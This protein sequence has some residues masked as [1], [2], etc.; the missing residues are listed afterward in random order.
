MAK[1][2]SRGIP[3]TIPPGESSVFSSESSVFSVCFGTESSES[4]GASESSACTFSR[5]FSRQGL[6]SRQCVQSSRSLR[7]FSVCRVPRSFKTQIKS[8]VF[9]VFRL[10]SLAFSDFV[11]LSVPEIW[12][13]VPRGFPGESPGD[14]PGDSPGNPPGPLGRQGCCCTPSTTRCHELV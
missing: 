11:K 14:P 1:I 7:A 5:V 8:K 13:A 6:P 4:P 12:G 10:Q 2:P 3:Q 9:I